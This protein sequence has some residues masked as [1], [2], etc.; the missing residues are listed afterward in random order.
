VYEFL[1]ET[2]GTNMA[3][4]VRSVVPETTVADLETA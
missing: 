4:S 1:Q 2:V 3:R